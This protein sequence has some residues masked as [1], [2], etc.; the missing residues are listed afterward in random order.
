M[1][2]NSETPFE[3]DNI[4]QDVINQGISDA[5]VVPYNKG[6]RISVKKALK[7]LIPNL[8]K[9]EKFISFPIPDK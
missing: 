3:I 8:D 6:L 4:R 5:F 7:I 2:Y 1:V 9:N